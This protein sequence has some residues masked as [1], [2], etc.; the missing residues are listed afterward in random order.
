MQVVHARRC[1]IDVHKKSVTACVMLTDATGTASTQVHTFSTMTVGLLALGDWLQQCG[2]THV[3]MESTAIYW[4]PVFNVLE[5]AHTIILVNAQ[6]I[7]AVPGRKTDVRDAEWLADLLRHGLLQPSFIPPAPIRN[8]RDLTRYRKTLIGERTQEINRLH[9]VLESANIKLGMVATDV[10]GTSGRLML[11]ALLNGEEDPQVLA[12]LARGLLRK[13]LPALQQALEGR[14]QPHHRVLLRQILAHVDFLE[15]SI[16]VVQAEVGQLLDPMAED[17][18]LLQTIP[19][20]SKQA[21][22]TIVAEIGT[23]M[24]RFPSAKHLVNWAG[25]CPGNRQSGGKR[26]SS[27]PTQGNTWLKAVLGEVAW[28]IARLRE[29]NYLTAHYRRIARR[30]GRFKALVAVSHTVLSIAYHLLTKR[31]P[32]HDLGA[33]YLDRLD[34]DRIQ[35]HHIRRLN[36]L[37]F[38][39]ALTPR[40]VS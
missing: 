17:V 19:G 23:D 3:A 40:L 38:D 21:A 13:K 11:A 37:G 35:Q 39:V 28:V 12:D 20:V 14:V 15:R 30:R 36:A 9:K 7:K 5:E 1:G 31:Q 2:V 32:Y 33:E 18:A 26:L 4:R 6:H 10:L 34:H 29:P 24:R 27:K 25:V 8:L 22:T 16:A